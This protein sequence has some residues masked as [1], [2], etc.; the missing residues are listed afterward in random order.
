MRSSLL[1][2]SLLLLVSLSLLIPRLIRL[3]LMLRMIRLVFDLMLI[4]RWVHYL[5]RSRQWHRPLCIIT[6]TKPHTTL[7]LRLLAAWERRCATFSA[8]ALPISDS[9]LNLIMSGIH[10][11]TTFQK[12][13]KKKKHTMIFFFVRTLCHFYLFKNNS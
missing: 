7:C 2:P 4:L 1:L 10:I 11:Y 5:G 3:I 6:P 9:L 8:R 13:K 12:A